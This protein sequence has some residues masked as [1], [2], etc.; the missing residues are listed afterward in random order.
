[1]SKTVKGIGLNKISIIGSAVLILFPALLFAGE[2]VTWEWCVEQAKNNNPEL[3]SSME[4]VMQSMADEG[5]SLSAA[6]PHIDTSASATRSKS[7]GGERTETYS[8]GVSGRQLLFDGFATASA[9]SGASKLV[10][11]S[12]YNHTLV[13]SNIRLDLR[14]AFIRLMR[15]RELVEI[16][17]SIEER[18]RQNYELVDLRYKGGREHKGSLLTAEADLAQAEFEVRQAERNVIL[19]SRQL[20]KQLGVGMGTLFAAEG[21]FSLKKDHTIDPDIERIADTTPFLNELI[22]RKDAARYNLNAKEAA[23]MPKVYLTGSFRRFDKDLLPGKD[24]WSGGLSFSLPVF[25]GGRR[26]FEMSRARSRSDQALHNTRSGRDTIIVTLQRTWNDLQDAAARVSVQQKFLNAAE[27][28]ARIAS[29]QYSTGLVSFND[30]IIIEDNLV[31][32]RNAYV[33]AQ[34]DMLV[35]EAYWVQARGGTLEYD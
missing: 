15:A 23:F 19:S 21:V 17:R 13:S 2:P 29:A 4:N 8:Y 3:M 35:S 24:D 9:V 26:I 5:V 32:A 11:A 6:L 10:D 18:R 20:A 31:R 12:L 7:H 34:S 25:E 27:E 14:I 16:T 22:A 28:R 1:M 30:W 33:N